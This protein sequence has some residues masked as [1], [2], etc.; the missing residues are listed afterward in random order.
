MPSTISNLQKHRIKQLVD[1]LIINRGVLT[2]NREISDSSDQDE[3]LKLAFR[4]YKMIMTGKSPLDI[5]E[6]MPDSAGS[7]SGSS[8]A[9]QKLCIGCNQPLS[10]NTIARRMPVCDDCL[11]KIKTDYEILREL[12]Q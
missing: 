12:F 2:V 6:P 10:E 9:S 11:K 5:D 1:E 3:I 4:Y 8:E 7:Q